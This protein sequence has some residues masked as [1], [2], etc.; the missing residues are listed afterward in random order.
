MITV[1]FKMPD[2]PPVSVVVATHDDLQELCWA[3]EDSHVV[4]SYT[5]TEPQRV[6][7]TLEV[8]GWRDRSFPKFK[9]VQEF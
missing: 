3:F 7:H 4:Q 1:M 9:Y 5:I 6:I 2:G 8:Y